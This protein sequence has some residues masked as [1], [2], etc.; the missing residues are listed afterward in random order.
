VVGKDNN[1]EILLDL[2]QKSGVDVSGIVRDAHRPT[3]TK[4]RIMA[5]HQQMIR[6]DEESTQDIGKGVEQKLLEKIAQLAGSV[7]AVIFEDY[8]K[9]VI[10]H[11]LAQKSIALFKR[12]KIFIGVDP[13]QKN[14]HYYKGA[15]LVKPNRKEAAQ[16]VKR[17]LDNTGEILW[18]A[19]KIRRDLRLS[20]V[21]VTLGER[22]MA[23]YEKSGCFTEFPS[24]ARKVYDV[25]GAGDTVISVL[26]AFAAAGAGMQ[27]ASFLA[28][29]AAGLVVAEVGAASVTLDM[30]RD[31][32]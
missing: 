9:G 10:T 2:M 8:N 30:I 29:Q 28:N 13:K 19:K 27:E 15:T 26:C 17:P 18:A 20:A 11:A 3:T 31:T 7:D 12:K 22:G 23:L 25:T 21:L 6:T 1:G 16:M 5:H 4:T 32:L 14:F 24:A